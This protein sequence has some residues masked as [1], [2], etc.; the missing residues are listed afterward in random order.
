MVNG[1]K[2]L[3]QYLNLWQFIIGTAAEAELGPNAE[4]DKV[5]PTKLNTFVP[6]AKN[7]SAGIHW[8]HMTALIRPTPH[9]KPVLLS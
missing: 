9:L 7:K 1:V 8:V 6:S 5:T 2:H 3:V 4:P